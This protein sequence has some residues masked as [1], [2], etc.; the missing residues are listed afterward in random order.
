M[1]ISNEIVFLSQHVDIK[2]SQQGVAQVSK[3]FN[4]ETFAISC[5]EFAVG[6]QSSI[7]SSIRKRIFPGTVVAA[8]LI[9]DANFSEFSEKPATVLRFDCQSEKLTLHLEIF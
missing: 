9:A 1:T 2:Q 7:L 4:K 5:S 6:T 8:Y 3:V